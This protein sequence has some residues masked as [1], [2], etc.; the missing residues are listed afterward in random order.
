MADSRRRRRPE[1]RENYVDPALWQSIY[2]IFRRSGFREDEAEWAADN[3]LDPRGARANEV[4]KILKNRTDRIRV[5]MKY[6]KEP[7][8]SREEVV[9]FLAEQRRRIA[10][11]Q[12]AVDPDN[13]FIGET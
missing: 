11:E 1:R 5:V 9:E 12:G 6:T 4:R 2:N 8:P 13:I 3:N 7:K 10:R